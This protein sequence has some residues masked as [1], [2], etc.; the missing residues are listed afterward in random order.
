MFPQLVDVVIGEVKV[1]TDTQVCQQH[2][3]KAEHQAT[4]PHV[5]RPLMSSVVFGSELKIMVHRGTCIM[6]THVRTIS[7][8]Y[9]GNDGASNSDRNHG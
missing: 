6:S 1:L 9:S 2:S 5:D 8:Y 4:S 7:D 3:D